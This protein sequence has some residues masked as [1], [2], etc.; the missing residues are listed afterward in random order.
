MKKVG[1]LCPWKDLLNYSC[2][3]FNL[4]LCTAALISASVVEPFNRYIPSYTCDV[5]TFWDQMTPFFKKCGLPVSCKKV[6]AFFFITRWSRR[7]MENICYAVYKECGLL[8]WHIALQDA[9]TALESVMRQK[10]LYWYNE[11]FYKKDG[12]IWSWKDV[13]IPYLRN[14]VIQHR[15]TPHTVLLVCLNVQ[16]ILSA[17]IL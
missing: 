16:H 15:L 4:V 12:V 17:T 3:S 2:K 5:N 9:S 11:K 1:V 6:K 14:F 10:F 13:V 8:T 7:I